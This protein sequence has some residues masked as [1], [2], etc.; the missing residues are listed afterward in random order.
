MIE[1]AMRR[2]PRSGWNYDRYAGMGWALLLLERYRKSIIWTQRALASTRTSDTAR[3]AQYDIR[4]AAAYSRL[5]RFDEAHR[6]L[7]DANQLWPYYTVR[8]L[9]PAGSSSHVYARQLESY[10]AA[11]RLA[12]LRDHAEE[13]ADF[14]VPADGN[15]HQNRAG[16]TPIATPGATTIRTAALEQLLNERKPIVIDITPVFVGPVDP[17][18]G[19]IGECRKLQQHVRRI[20]GP[21]AQEDAF[22]DQRGSLNADCCGRL[23]LGAL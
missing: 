4:L 18:R 10:Q 15:L 21:A 14:G 9:S 7:A 17:R 3:L 19:R 22:I 20:A 23:E 2:D 1:K 5:E 13:D 16:L 8:I 11:L 6:A 12:G